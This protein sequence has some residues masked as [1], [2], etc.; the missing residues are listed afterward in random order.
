MPCLGSKQSWL[1]FWVYGWKMHI[2][3]VSVF[4]FM[5]IVP[6]LYICCKFL[7][8]FCFWIWT[9]TA[10]MCQPLVNATYIQNAKIHLY[11]KALDVNYYNGDFEVTIIVNFIRMS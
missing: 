2:N 5:S 1:I 8:L 3:L 7:L 6:L 11:H 10:R 9:K 4:V